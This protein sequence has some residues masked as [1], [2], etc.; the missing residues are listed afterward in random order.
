MVAGW[1]YKR[2]PWPQGAMAV[3]IVLMFMYGSQSAWESHVI[4]TQARIEIP[5]PNAVQDLIDHPDTPENNFMPFED[6]QDDTWTKVQ[7]PSPPTLIRSYEGESFF[8]GWAFEEGDDPTHGF[9]NYVN[10]STAFQDSLAY[11][12]DG[13]A[14]MSVDALTKLNLGQKRKS[15]RVQSEETFGIGSLVILDAS[16]IPYGYGVWGAWWMLG[17]VCG[18]WAG[19]QTTWLRS[20][21][22]AKRYPTCADGVTDPKLYENAH[23]KINSLKIYSI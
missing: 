12:E 17:P 1:P 11:V 13:A 3:F 6:D 7:L 15:I 16:H 10:R 4:E 21:V 5:E 19:D 9:V 18:D 20:G 22:S 8:D 23:W 14:F 2:A